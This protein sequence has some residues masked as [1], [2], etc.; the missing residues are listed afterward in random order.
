MSEPPR[1]PLRR[2]TR[3]PGL[4]LRSRVRPNQRC[5]QR[6]RSQPQRPSRR[7]RQT[8]TPARFLHPPQRPRHLRRPHP[9]RSPRP[10][11]PMATMA[12]ILLN[13]RHRRA[14]PHPIG[15]LQHLT[16]R[17][18]RFRVRHPPRSRRV[19][20]TVMMKS[21]RATPTARRMNPARAANRTTTRTAVDRGSSS[22]STPV[23]GEGLFRGPAA[24]DSGGRR[25]HFARRAPRLR[26]GAPPTRPGCMARTI[27]A[28]D[29]R[30]LPLRSLAA[31]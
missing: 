7:Q 27:R 21:R 6:P 8:R 25:C 13:L 26:R 17:P 4:P 19:N 16:A 1:R 23:A 18:L 11:R 9:P 28:G 22:S 15:P 20:R 24:P 3:A 5:R 29:A 14:R 10:A 12:R 2:C 31:R 30:D